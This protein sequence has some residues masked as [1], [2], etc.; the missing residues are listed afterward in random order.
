MGLSTRPEPGRP[1]ITAP[2]AAKILRRDAR[3]IRRMIKDG[4]LAGYVHTGQNQSR[5]YVYRDQIPILANPAAPGSAPAAD[6]QAPYSDLQDE[7]ASLRADVA[8]LSETNQLL[9]AAQALILTAVDHYQEASEEVAGVAQDQLHLA[10]RYHT[11]T[12]HFRSSADTFANALRNYRDIIAELIAPANIS[13]IT[14]APGTDPAS[15]SDR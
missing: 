6:T 7:V 3:T 13:G 4:D 9:L 8:S 1:S 2:Q 5:W 15:D 12:G 14:G 10:E 11:A